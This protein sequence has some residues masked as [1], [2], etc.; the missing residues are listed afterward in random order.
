MHKIFREETP[1]LDTKIK[2]EYEDE[3]L[4]AVN[5]PASIPVHPCGNFKFNSLTC[6][7]EFE[8]DLTDLHTVHR[9]DR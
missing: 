1:V 5:K 2:I 4:L 9:L 8:H 7:L 3:S 6:L